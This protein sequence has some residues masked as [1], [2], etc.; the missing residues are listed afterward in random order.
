MIIPIERLDIALY[1]LTANYVLATR[2]LE[3]SE[4]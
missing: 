2:L 4:N 3:K 1:V